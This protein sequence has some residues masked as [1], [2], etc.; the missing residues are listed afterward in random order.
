MSEPAPGYAPVYTPATPE[1][2]GDRPVPTPRTFT[3]TAEV[4]AQ[5][6]ARFAVS[7]VVACGYCGRMTERGCCVP[8]ERQNSPPLH[9]YMAPRAITIAACRA[10]EE[11]VARIDALLAQNDALSA[12]NLDLAQQVVA[13]TGRVAELT[14]ALKRAE[15]GTPAT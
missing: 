13:L 11:R 9:G 3:P 2:A 10:C 5:L 4:E 8:C 6:D 12:E 1:G 7:G 15:K 14:C